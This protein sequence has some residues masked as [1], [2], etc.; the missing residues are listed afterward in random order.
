MANGK[1]T[2]VNAATEP[3]IEDLANVLNKMGAK[4]TG[5]GTKKL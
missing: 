5:A 4:I 2:I 1:T 3:E